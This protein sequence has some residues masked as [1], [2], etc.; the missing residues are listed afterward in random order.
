MAAAG[1]VCAGLMRHKHILLRELT[2]TNILDVLVKKGIF[3]VADLEL[4]TSAADSEKC[5]Y[6]VDV[7][8]KQSGSKLNDLCVVLNNECPKL[9]KELMNDRHRFIVNGYSTDCMKDNMVISQNLHRES[10]RSRRSVSQCSCNSMSRRSSA[11]ASPMPMQL[12]PLNNTVEMYVEPVV[13][14]VSIMMLVFFNTNTT[15]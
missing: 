10:P 8:S 2:D 15:Y 13:E 7:V 5:N 1:N 6:F 12:P 9:T 14:D 4:I 3:S 11:A